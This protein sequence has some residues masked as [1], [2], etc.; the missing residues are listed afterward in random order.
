MKNYLAKILVVFIASFV[1]IVGTFPQGIFAAGTVVQDM[2]L[3]SGVQYKQYTYNNGNMNA[4]HHLAV[5]LNDEYTKVSL[6]MPSTLTTRERTTV[7]ANGNSFEGNRVVGAINAAFFS[8][9]EGNPLFLIAENNR[10]I[11][12]GI[13]SQGADEYM[14][15]PT[16]FGIQSDGSGIIDYFNNNISM[17]YQGNSYTLNGLNRQRRIGEAVVYTPQNYSSITGTNEYGVEIVVD[18]GK[19]ITSNYFGQTLTGVVSQ[20]KPYGSKE[21]LTIPKNGFVISIQGEQWRAI[22]QS[23]Q[24]GEEISVHFSIDE[25]WQDAQFIIG[26]GPMLVRNGQ[27][28]IMM[29]TASK[30]A[31]EIAPRT[32]VGISKDKKTIHYITVDGRQSHSK[33]MNMTQLANYLIELGIDTAINL[34]G[35]GSTTMGIR[36]YG[37]NNIVLVNKPSDGSERKVS[38][39]LQAI[40][41]APTSRA[42]QIKFARTK[43]GTFLAGAASTLSVSYLLDTFYNPVPFTDAELS[44]GSQNQTLAI[45]HLTYKT[46]KAGDDR[47]YILHK[48]VVVQSFPVKTVDAPATMSIQSS[49]TSIMTGQNATFK[50]TAQDGDGKDL[51]YEPAQLQ[52]S[53][54]GNIGTISSSGN[55]TAGKEG[56]TGKVVAKL[57]TKT[58]TQQITVVKPSV[59]KDIPNNYEYRKE[60]EYLVSKKIISGYTDGTFKPAHNLT[61]AQAAVILTR[62]LGLNTTAVKNPG[63]KDVPITHPHY[64]EIAAVV[65]SGIMS[66]K[67]GNVF[68]PAN[69]LTRGQMAKVL[70]NAYHLTG[71]GSKSFKDVPVNY[72]GYKDIQVLVANHITSGFADGTFKPNTPISRVHFSVF[73][74]RTMQSS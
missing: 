64:K 41:T 48:G 20:V 60:V 73:L 1:I 36:Q 28:Y 47:I 7:I 32:V 50:I 23:A 19:P 70:V 74:Y 45:N 42:T 2:P 26:S 22:L 30:R 69:T 66:G 53:V 11:N 57:G 46:T 62:A 34:D 31:T 33:G 38:T 29:S 3:S 10:I 61:R 27:P 35:G 16:A 44:L 68:A 58:V 18:T 39:I 4:I 43:V 65:Q 71:N 15:Q 54:E 13:V 17:E 52:W 72:W 51:I 21:P 24:L 5:N 8:M 6:G 55:F 37:S 59:F 67:S 12:G 9:S 14:N 49:A 25:K 40:S 56:G 63:L